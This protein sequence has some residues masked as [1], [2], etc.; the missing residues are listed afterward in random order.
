MKNVCPQALFVVGA[1]AIVVSLN[2]TFVAAQSKTDGAGQQKASTSD[3]CCKIIKIDTETALV[4][5]R[6]IA[7]G[8]TFHFV[9]KDRAFIKNLK[10]NLPVNFN[11]RRGLSVRGL[12]SNCCRPVKP[13]IDCSLDPSPCP[14]RKPKPPLGFE[15]TF[16]DDLSD[17]CQELSG[18]KPPNCVDPTQAKP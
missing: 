4:T 10:V 12:P 14:G 9:L 13:E 6:E 18:D 7:T 1:L 15:T 5:A 8:R 17:F 3:P 16:W 11:R 2:T